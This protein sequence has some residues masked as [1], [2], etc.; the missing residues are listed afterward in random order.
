[1]AT[2]AGVPRE[3]GAEEEVAFDLSRLMSLRKRLEPAA[4]FLPILG[5]SMAPM[6]GIL[7][8]FSGWGSVGWLAVWLGLAV[9]AG[10]FVLTLRLSAR[11]KGGGLVS[12]CL[13][14]L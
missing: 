12:I 11:I 10:L 7:L 3:A 13:V 14:T 5:F 6:A 9:V 4:F 8:A 2:V 1:M